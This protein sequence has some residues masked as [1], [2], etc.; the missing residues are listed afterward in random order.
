MQR[1]HIATIN[2]E[3]NFYEYQPKDFENHGLSA[4]EIALI[5]AISI[6]KDGASGGT[7]YAKKHD[8]EAH[9]YVIFED[10]VE[11]RAETSYNEETVDAFIKAICPHESCTNA[12]KQEFDNLNSAFDEP[13]IRMLSQCTREA[14]AGYLRLEENDSENRRAILS[15]SFYDHPQHWTIKSILS[16]DQKM[17]WVF[18][19]GSCH[20]NDVLITASI[21]LYNLVATFQLNPFQANIVALLGTGLHLTLLD[22]AVLAQNYLE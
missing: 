21:I 11:Q 1:F 16:I 18:Q 3:K 17:A 8:H 5:H 22:V 4:K 14:F 2:F 13:D 9:Q 10:E 7:L 19:H 15:P 6:H 12:Y 20:P